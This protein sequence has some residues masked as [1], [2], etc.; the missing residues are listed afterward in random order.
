MYLREKINL[1]VATKKEVE[2]PWDG[3]NTGCFSSQW[4]ILGARKL[5][6]KN[7]KT[8]FSQYMLYSLKADTHYFTVFIYLRNWRGAKLGIFTHF[9]FTKLPRCSKSIVGNPLIKGE[10]VEHSKNWVTWG[11]GVPKIFPERG[12]NPEKGVDV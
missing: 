9:T 6:P 7:L 11:G 1:R 4:P 8:F 5:T 12:D 3:H 2:K 10:G